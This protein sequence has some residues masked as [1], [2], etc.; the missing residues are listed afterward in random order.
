MASA[1][2]KYIADKLAAETL[3]P[4]ISDGN[5]IIPIGFIPKKSPMYC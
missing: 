1:V 4:S 5:Q 3:Y 2:D